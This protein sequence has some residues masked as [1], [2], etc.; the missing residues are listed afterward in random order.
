MKT[1][2]ALLGTAAMV[3]FLGIQGCSTT[4]TKSPDVS[5]SIQDA[6]KQAGFKDVSVNDD[7]DKGVVTLKGSVPSDGDKANAAGIAKGIAG[8]QVVANEIA[9][10]PPGEQADARTIN[11]DLDGGIKKN[12]DAALIGHGLQDNVTFDVKN[13]VVTL[14]GKVP[15]ETTRTAVQ[16]VAAGV[17]YV[18]QVVNKLDVKDQ[19]ATTTR[20]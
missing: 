12:L 5:G 16:Q 14:N 13:G 10:L 11:S 18:L 7:R 19:K 15:S 4:T 17:P 1:F 2:H 6:L 9:V 20:N 8:S 3:G